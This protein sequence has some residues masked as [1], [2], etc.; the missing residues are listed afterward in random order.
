MWKPF[1]SFAVVALAAQ[2]SWSAQPYNLIVIQTDEHNFRTLGCYRNTL[3]P[4]QAFVW[5]PE[6]VVETPHLDSIAERGAICTSFYVNSPVCTP[7]RAA[8]FSG[9]YPQNTNAWQNDRPYDSR[10]VTWAQVLSDHGYASGYAGKWHL[11]GSGKPQWAPKRRFGFADNRFMFNRGHWKMFELNTDGPRVAALDRKGNPSYGITGA[12]EKSFATDWLCDRLLDFI[13]EHAGEPFCYHLS[14]PDPHGPNT[15]R[16]PYDTAFENTP[17]RPPMTFARTD[18]NP[19]WA[20]INN[21]NGA[22]K[23]NASLMQAS[24][25]MVACID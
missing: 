10:V 16:P 9:C 4:D 15:V 14:L 3:T 6:A 22:K 8:F 1:V 11:D 7:S 17:V 5:G 21:K 13:D 23:F 2:A 24:F 19:K 20:P 12:D 18:A 25:G